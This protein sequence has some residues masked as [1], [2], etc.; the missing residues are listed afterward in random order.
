MKPGD[1]FRLESA[2]SLHGGDPKGR[3]VV[4]VS[5]DVFLDQPVFVV[6]CSSTI[7]PEQEPECVALPWH[8]QGLA[9]TGFRKPT[10]AVPRWLLKV[11]PSDLGRQVGDVPRDKLNAIIAM[12]PED[13]HADLTNETEPRT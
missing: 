1:I 8:R 12:L 4:V 6:A 2:P 11:R 10:W 13:P 9:R 5:A 7:R 3:Y